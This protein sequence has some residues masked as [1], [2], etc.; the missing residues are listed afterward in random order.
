ME[1]EK[2]VVIETGGSIGEIANRG[3]TRL[4]SFTIFDDKEEAKAK[5][6]SMSKAYGGGYY[7]YH[8]STKTLTWAKK[9]LKP[10]ELENLK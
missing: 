9:N 6:R 8:Y 7:D 2:Y 4:G 3:H 10:S 5:T 1:K